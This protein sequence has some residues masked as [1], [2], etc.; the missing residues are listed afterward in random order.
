M[1]HRSQL[2]IAPASPQPPTFWRVI[3]GC[4]RAQAAAPKLRGLLLITDP[5]DY[6]VKSSA[7]LPRLS[8]VRVRVCACVCVCWCWVS[9]NSS[10]SNEPWFSM[11]ASSIVP[12]WCAPSPDMQHARHLQFHHSGPFCPPAQLS[13]LP[14]SLMSAMLFPLLPASHHAVVN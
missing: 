3:I 8:R 10:Q 2:C 14:L 13:S 6:H 12:P 9:T 1:L 5:P 4:W 7:Q 11:A